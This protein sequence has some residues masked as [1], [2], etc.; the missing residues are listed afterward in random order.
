[1]TI[2]SIYKADQPGKPA[3]NVSLPDCWEELNGE[4]FMHVAYALYAFTDSDE[5]HAYILLHLLGR[6]HALS[7]PAEVLVYQIFPLLDWIYTAPTFTAQL[8]PQVKKLLLCYYGPEGDFNNLTISEF[9]FAE[10]EMYQWL[11]EPGDIDQL[12][13]FVACLYR[14]GKK[15]YNKSLDKDGDIREVF[16]ANTITYHAGQLKKHAFAGLAFAT[17]LWYK[18]CRNKLAILYPLVFQQ[19]P[20]DDTPPTQEGGVT[21]LPNCFNLMRKIAE[22]GTYGRMD[23]VEKMYLHTVMLELEYSIKESLKNDNK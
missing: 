7:I 3:F 21:E 13:R 8:I 11:Q 17:F 2:L 9:D 5:R 10:R 12:W 23:E 1:M 20:G 4:Q 16:N 22:K 15:R 18:A 19:A 6:K 14:P